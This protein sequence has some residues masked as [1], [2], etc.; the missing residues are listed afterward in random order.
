MSALSRPQPPCQVPRL[1]LL[2]LRENDDPI[3]SALGIIASAR[4][5]GLE[6]SV[7]T[8]GADRHLPDSGPQARLAAASGHA[9][10]RIDVL[11]DITTPARI[12]ERIRTD[13]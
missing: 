8:I 5:E 2:A 1:C 10:H 6:V 3:P 13:H 11:A 7:C 12:A 4:A 9:V